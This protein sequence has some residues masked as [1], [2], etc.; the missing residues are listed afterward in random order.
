MSPSDKGAEMSAVAEE[1][2]NLHMLDEARNILS[3]DSMMLATAEHLRCLVAII[4][5]AAPYLDRP[6]NEETF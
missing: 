4:D 5:Q 2:Y 3:G 1:A 6:T